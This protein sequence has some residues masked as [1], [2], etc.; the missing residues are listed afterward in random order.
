MEGPVQGPFKGD[1]SLQDQ[2]A[3]CYEQDSQERW[4]MI[5]D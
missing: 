1:V 4:M 5:V 3:S 2:P